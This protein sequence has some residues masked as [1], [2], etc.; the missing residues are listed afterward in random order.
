MPARLAATH[1]HQSS[2]DFFLTPE[3]PHRADVGNHQDDFVL[4]LHAYR[5]QREPDEL[6][7]QT[8]ARAVVGDLG[9]LV[10]KGALRHI[11]T[12]AERRVPAPPVQLAIADESPKL[13][14]ARGK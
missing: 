14:R 1:Q 6:E 9:H 4:I 13:I 12:K 3:V 11:V 8:A 2:K 7:A 10:L 5:A